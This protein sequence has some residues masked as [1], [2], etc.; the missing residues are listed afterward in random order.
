MAV[1]L[2]PGHEMET[3]FAKTLFAAG[4]C[5]INPRDMPT[6]QGSIHLFRLFGIDVYLHWAWFLAIAYFTYQ[7]ESHI[8]L[9]WKVLQCLSLFLIVLMHEFGHSLAC[10]Q[11]GGQANQ[12]VLWPLG[13]VAYVSPPQRPGAMLWSIAA[14]PLV[15]VLL[16]PLLGILVL[17][18]Q[19]LG[20]EESFPNLYDYVMALWIIDIILLV[21]NLLPIY[22]LDGGQILRSLLWFIFGRARSLKIT[23]IIGFIGLAAMIPFVVMAHNSWYYVLAAFVALNCWTGFQ[24][25]RA[26]MRLADAPRHAGFACPVCRAAP[27]Q[28][29]FWVCG[30]CRKSFD[31]FVTG[32]TCPQCGTQYGATFCPECSSLRPMNEWTTAGNAPP[33]L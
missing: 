8:P 16:F 24:Q 3:G 20:W 21:F 9:T 27:P 22:P 30:K 28:G 15:N 13:G 12:I 6:R 7:P 11:V 29:P 23:T 14:G 1:R 33:K 32:A 31:T 10:K 4:R 25:A 2:K 5:V 18:A 19:Y 17:I 26:M